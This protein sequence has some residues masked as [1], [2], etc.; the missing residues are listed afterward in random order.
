MSVARLLLLAVAAR[1]RGRFDLA[2]E[3]CRQ[4]LVLDPEGTEARVELAKI[5]WPGLPYLEVLAALHNI[6]RPQRYIEIGVAAGDSLALARD[7]A[8]A[9]G[10]D[11]A[12]T[13]PADIRATLRRETAGA[14]FARGGLSE[15]LGGPGFDMA[16]IDGAHAFREVL[17]DFQA[18]ARQAQ[19]HSLIV[20]HDCLPLDALSSSAI[21]RTAFWTGDGWKF[22]ALLTQT[23]PQLR[24]AT[25]QCPPSGL[26][27]VSGFA[28]ALAPPDASQIAAF[29]ALSYE[30][31]ASYRE[32]LR[33]CPSDSLTET[34]RALEFCL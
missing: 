20:L 1:A 32:A 6:L 17:A 16:F 33:L 23:W 31:F 15:D 12:P 5:L 25:V 29:D 11:P 24:W 28:P 26:L 30:D 9:I 8:V 34:L 21:R 7:C 22:G 3:A 4:A 27:L 18:L 19:P 2:E 13:V 14:Y 10:I